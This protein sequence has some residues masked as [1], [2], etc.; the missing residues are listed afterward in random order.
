MV[1]P[2]FGRALVPLV[3]LALTG[4]V[5]GPVEGQGTG[6]KP[7]EVTE[8][9][10]AEIQRAMQEGRLTA[11]SLVEAY[12]DRIEAYDK[13][14]PASSGGSMSERCSWRRSRVTSRDKRGGP[15]VRT[16][17]RKCGST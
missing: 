3:A 14:G 6:A 10:I 16:P 12:L 7:F 13:C 11:R 5:A 1:G 8:A 15:R 2:R 17:C 4:L 9:S